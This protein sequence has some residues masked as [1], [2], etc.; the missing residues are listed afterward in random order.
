MSIIFAR[1]HSQAV[2]LRSRT[3]REF[4]ASPFH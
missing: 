3:T 1:E 2:R 4:P